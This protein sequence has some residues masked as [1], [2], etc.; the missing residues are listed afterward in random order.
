MFNQLTDQQ[1][2]RL[3]YLSEELGEA[4]KA[5]AKILRHGYASGNP[6]KI[7][8]QTDKGIVYDNKM[9]LEDEM[10]DVMRAMN[11][12]CRAGELDVQRMTIQSMDETRVKKYLHR[13]GELDVQRMTIQSMDE[14][15][16][17]KYLHH[18]ADI[19]F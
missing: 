6:D 3:F 5:V 15:R 10:S 4:Q 14:T 12:L 11:F 19:P 8:N 13:A 2:E 17:K 16:V 7:V 9:E 1:M 18:D